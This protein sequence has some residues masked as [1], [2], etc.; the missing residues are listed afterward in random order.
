MMIF[1]IKDDTVTSG[2]YGNWNAGSVKLGSYQE[3]GFRFILK[4]AGGGESVVIYPQGD[5]KLRISVPSNPPM[6]HMI[7]KR[8]Q[9]DPSRTT[10]ADVGE[11]GINEWVATLQ[12]VQ[13]VLE[14]SPPEAA[15][16]TVKDPQLELGEAVRKGLIRKA[17][18]EDVGAFRNAYIQK[19]YLKNGLPA[20]EDED[21]LS[22]TLVDISRAY[23]VLKK[24][25]YP[26][27]LVN[28]NRAVFLVPIGVP[29]PSGE[30]GHSAIYYFDSLT[31]EC[32]LER[33][34]RWR[35]K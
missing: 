12:R 21:A 27:G 23:V 15:P 22:I 5:G 6:Y 35:C 30:Y 19:K 2:M 11:I 14:S 31:V 3:G 7:W 4:M 28:S 13:K 8:T 34:S 16:L 18:A 10:P 1:E 29:E 32:T 24:F 20:P 26:S 33:M 17:T 9:L 25:S